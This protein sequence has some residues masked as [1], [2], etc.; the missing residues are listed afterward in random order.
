M[1]NNDQANTISKQRLITRRMFILSFA[2]VIVFTG[3]V[4]RLFSLQISENKKYSFL[5]DKNRLKT[6]K[7]PPKRGMFEDYF[8]NKI[9][10]NE[11][12]FQLHVVPEE[13][14]DFNYLILRLKNII[15]LKD[16]ELG[17]IYKKKKNTT[18]LANINYFR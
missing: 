17:T 2:K 4:G 14:E 5:S 8:G 15:K 11:R 13:V 10:D 9:A 3:I 6:W 7:L 1:L 18:F 16:K 12:V